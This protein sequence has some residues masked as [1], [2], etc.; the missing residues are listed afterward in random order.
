[1]NHHKVKLLRGFGLS[2]T[3]KDHKIILKNGRHFYESTS[4]VESYFPSQ[5]PY[6]RIIISGKGN[7]STE[8]I[9]TWGS[10]NVSILLTDTYGNILGSIN[11]PMS[12]LVA[13]RHR[14]TQYDTFRDGIKVNYLQKQILYAK[15]FS[16]IKFLESLPESYLQM[17]NTRGHFSKTYYRKNTNRVR[18]YCIQDCKLTKKLSEYFIDLF[19]R[20]FKFYP[21][22]WVS[23]GYIAEK[24]LINSDVTF[25]LLQDLPE[26]VAN[27]AWNSYFGG[28][29]EMMQRGFIG[30]AHIYDINSAYP[31]AISQLPDLTKGD[32]YRGD[33]IVPNATVGFFKISV[34]ID[35]MKIVCPFPFRKNN[36]IIYPSGKFVTHC[37]LQELQVIDDVSYV[38]LDSVQF[39]PHTKKK[40]YKKFINN[41]YNKRLELKRNNDPMQM[42]I[43]IILNSIYGKTGQITNNRVGGM[44]NPV[45]FAYIT[46]FTR[47]MLYQFMKKH[48]LEN[49]IVA[50]A[51]DSI[52]ITKKLNVN[53]QKLGGFSF[54]ASGDDCYFL[55]NG[56][57]RINGSW[58]NRGIG[59]YKGKEIE[60][61]DTIQRD[62]NLFLIYEELRV[63]RLI[64]SIVSKNLQNIG[65]FSKKEKKINL[66]ADHKRFWLE[67]LEGVGTKKNKS[68]P[69]SMNYFDKDEI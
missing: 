39:V 60:H 38:I 52:C 40:P 29:F 37:T 20:F 44:F 68:M 18:Q 59:R 8:A 21:R 15:I 48:Q 26:S 63:G 27:F 24:V 35:D 34:D 7:L 25:P 12:S 30:K 56:F 49:H 50:F 19:F 69:L 32:W 5:F 41:L 2:I 55:Q 10:K 67:R 42:P 1:M 46:G 23:S 9:K 61:L 22:R 13:S 6:E 64:S 66:N 45:I 14:M 53:S 3:I 54:E 33:E 36:S 58:K 16:E 11:P 28:R 47:A 62:D 65:K 17:K 31:Y 51:T 4:D 43:K 57:Y